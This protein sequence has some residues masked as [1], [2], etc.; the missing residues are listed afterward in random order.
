MQTLVRALKSSG[1][2]AAA[3]A[4]WFA[5]AEDVAHAEG[6]VAWTDFV[7]NHDPW[8]S[9]L[10]A[11]AFFIIEFPWLRWVAISVWPL[12]LA[13]AIYWTRFVRWCKECVARCRRWWQELRAEHA[14]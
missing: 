1:G 14:Q 6:G 13:A 12:S 11:A 5:L 7:V 2:Q 3:N 4:G 8:S 10:A 9:M